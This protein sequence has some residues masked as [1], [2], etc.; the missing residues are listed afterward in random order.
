MS[1][2][3]AAAAEVEGGLEVDHQ[4]EQEDHRVEVEDH[5]AEDHQQE[6]PVQDRDKPQEG[7]N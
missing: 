5:Q 1:R 4:V 3:S 2:P 7:P 6:V